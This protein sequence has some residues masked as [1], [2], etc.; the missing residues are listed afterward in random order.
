M[1]NNKMDSSLTDVDIA[2]PLVT[3]EFT[4]IKNDNEY[5]NSI[6]NNNNRTTE[7]VPFYYAKRG[8]L[9]KKGMG[10][11]Y[12]PWSLRHFILEVN[13]VLSYF[14]GEEIKG[15]LTLDG[16]SVREL[17]QDQADGKMYAFEIYN[18]NIAKLSKF[19]SQN[20]LLAASSKQERDM[21]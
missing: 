20:M 4:D 1:E 12:K 19:K 8:Y 9:L 6:S 15:V 10:K 16:A 3:S 21:W 14:A 17:S 2:S 7:T 11:F 18:L 13:Q 5:S